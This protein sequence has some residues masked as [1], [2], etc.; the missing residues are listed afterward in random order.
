MR[1]PTADPLLR[2]TDTSLARPLPPLLQAAR[3]DVLAAARDLWTIPDAVLA[4]PWSW[5]G[6]GEEEIRYGFYR[7]C[8][9]FE[10]AGH[11]A[12]VAI[13]SSGED[14][15][16]AADLIAPATA[17]RWDLQG[18]LVPLPDAT[19]SADPGEGEWNI[20]R[21]IG[22]VIE[23]QRSYGLGTAWWQAQGYR[24]DD[25]TVPAT[26]P[27]EA[28]WEE[29]PTEEQEA[30]GSPTEI[31]DRLDGALDLAT[32]RLSGLPADRLGLG[33]RWSGFTVDVGF[34]L[35]R[36][37]SHIREHTIQVEKTLVMLDHRPTEVDRLIRLVLAA[38]GRAEAVV[39]GSA[40][41][42]EAVEKLAAAAAGA[43]V[44]A[45][46]VADIARADA[47]G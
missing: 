18:L 38:W 24:A 11:D 23:A 10:L 46:E 37:A 7:L 41:A 17:A 21:T 12:A 31:R 20:R 25:P 14:R 2:Y 13:R 40:D 9:A 28:L 32:E 34:R 36:W 27:P 43:R 42:P 22:H 29:I 26:T 19:W 1:T 30:E 4:R 39:Y 3:G 8:E 45:A 5:K 15:G 35:G 6:G 47:A 33:A 16:R 44:T